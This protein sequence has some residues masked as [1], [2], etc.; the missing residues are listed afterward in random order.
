MNEHRIIPCLLLDGSRFVKTVQFANPIYVGD[1]VNVLSLFN[2]FEVDEVVLLDISGA[3]ERRPTSSA[4]LRELAAEC[5]I[6]LAY[7]GGLSSLDQMAAVFSAGYEKVVLN[8]LLAREPS[9]VSSAC[10]HFGS[11]AV[12]ASIDVRGES[13]R[14]WAVHV[15]AGGEPTGYSPVEWAER[16]E[17]LGVG[18]IL[19]T[20]VAR[21]GTMRGFDLELCSAVAD[22][23]SIP[24][25]AHGGAG[26]RKQLAEPVSRSGAS[27]VAA[28]SLFV[29]Q[30]PN[31]G[32]L[33]NYPSR[34]QVERLV[35]G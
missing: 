11:Q 19:L 23:V 29:F 35:G 16:A 27:A 32:V 18:E 22:A 4:L 20:S 6:P 34:T 17:A 14:D 31:R 33:I 25:I 9:T 7:G 10:E 15:A 12:V 30:G 1:P 28:G 24:V 13:P 8:T 26:R 2:S 5:F 3:R 21:E